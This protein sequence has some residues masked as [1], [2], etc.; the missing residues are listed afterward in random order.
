MG[1]PRTEERPKAPAF[2][3]SQPTK[4]KNERR[5]KIFMKAPFF[6]LSQRSTRRR[7]SIEILI[8]AV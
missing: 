4:I 8:P 1:V 5:I 3:T 6:P 7:W 2:P